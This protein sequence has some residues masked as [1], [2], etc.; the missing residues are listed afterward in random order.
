M[1][2]EELINSVTEAAAVLYRG[3]LQFKTAVFAALDQYRIV[4]QFER[5]VLFKEVCSRLG[6]R[7]N[8]HKQKLATRQKQNRFHFTP[9]RK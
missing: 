7:G 4:E 2:R 6:S 3:G 9:L 1:T 5:E 8:K